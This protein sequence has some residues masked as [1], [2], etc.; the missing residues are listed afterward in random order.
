MGR[1]PIGCEQR[2]RIEEKVGGSS[3]YL[4]PGEVG[5]VVGASWSCGGIHGDGLGLLRGEGRRSIGRCL[6][7]GSRIT[8]ASDVRGP[9]ASGLTL[10][11]TVP[12]CQMYKLKS[13]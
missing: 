12:T 4:S 5:E 8:V 7:C 9:L 6:T 11:A 2:V 1:R 10:S 3:R 13:V